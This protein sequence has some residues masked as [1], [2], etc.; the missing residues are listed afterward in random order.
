LGVEGLG[1]AVL[2]VGVGVGFGEEGRD[3]ADLGYFFIT[4]RHFTLL[5]SNY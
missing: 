5:R 2:G 1:E 3:G 4:Y